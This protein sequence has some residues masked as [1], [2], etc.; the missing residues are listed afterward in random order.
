MRSLVP[1]L[2]IV[3]TLVCLQFSQAEAWLLGGN[4]K[5][6]KTA[7]RGADGE[8]GA[9]KKAEEKVVEF[10]DFQ[11]EQKAD[12]TKKTPEVSTAIEELKVDE[13]T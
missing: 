10:I 13:K 8:E 6:G 7:L 11:G 12:A 1:I 2:F 4:K 9:E 3:I 5:T